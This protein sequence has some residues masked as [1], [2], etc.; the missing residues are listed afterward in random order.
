MTDPANHNIEPIL[1]ETLESTSD[2]VQPASR[3]LLSVS[4]T[5]L[6]QL[7]ALEVVLLTYVNGDKQYKEYFS[8]GE[9]K[10]SFFNENTRIFR[11][12]NYFTETEQYILESDL[13]QIEYPSSKDYNQQFYE[14]AKNQ[15]Q[16]YKQ[17]VELYNPIADF[18]NIK[19]MSKEEAYSAIY[20]LPISELQ[21]TK[22]CQSVVMYYITIALNK[23]VRK[24]TEEFGE[25]EG[26]ESSE[27][28]QEIVKFI[29]SAK[30]DY[31]I[32]KGAETY[33]Q[34]LCCCPTILLP[35]FFSKF[36]KYVAENIP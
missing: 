29:N 25:I 26:A 4:E 13:I 6:L 3:L 20:Q 34:I 30:G 18:T 14:R 8:A 7:S 21:N 2:E 36:E 19:R 35:S 16:E 22:K 5:A 11:L 23:E 9:N 33:E 28:L 12:T 32:F 17:V 10:T 24:L 31:S 27:E 15:K 1:H